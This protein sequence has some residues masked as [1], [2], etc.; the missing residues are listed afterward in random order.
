MLGMYGSSDLAKAIFGAGNQH[1]GAPGL[2]PDAV[3]ARA[4]R[5]VGVVARKSYA[6]PFV[7]L[8]S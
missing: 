1:A 6:C 5:S 7:M 8:G 3:V 2:A 4:R